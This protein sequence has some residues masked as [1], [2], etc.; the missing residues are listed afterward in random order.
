MKYIFATIS[1]IVFSLNLFS[2]TEKVSRTKFVLGLSIPEILHMGATYRISNSSLV[3]LNAGAGPTWGGLWPTINLEHR[4]YIGKT[5]EAINRKVWFFRQ[6]ATIF[7]AAENSQRLAITFTLGKD[8]LFKN[9]S[10][11]ITIDAG[12][13]M[14]RPEAFSYYKSLKIWPALRFELFF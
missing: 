8:I 11:G 5:N 6:G 10:N 12:F 7:T 1:L 4:L 2:Q 13:F 9:K 3:G 14:Q